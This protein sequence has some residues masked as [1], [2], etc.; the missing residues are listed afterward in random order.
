MFPFYIRQT[1]SDM[2]WGTAY[3]AS[4]TVSFWVKTNGAPTLPVRLKIAQNAAV[5]YITTVTVNQNLTWQY[6]SFTIPPPPVGTILST[7]NVDVFELSIGLYNTAFQVSTYNVWSNSN[8]GDNYPAINCYSSAGNYVEF[9]GVQ[10]EKGTIATP[11][12]F[13]PY[14]M[15]LQL[16]QRYYQSFKNSSQSGHILIGNAYPIDANN[17]V[18]QIT[19]PGGPMR[20]ATPRIVTGSQGTV[21]FSSGF[22]GA[23]TD[24]YLWCAA[25]TAF[26]TN[27]YGLAVNPMLNNII[28][29]RFADNVAKLTPN[30]FYHVF[31][32]TS[33]SFA[34][35]AEL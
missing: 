19:L 32:E 35:S 9:T 11:F 4:V 29:L 18:A 24:V 31:V 17:A 14:V 30:Q 28:M 27:F 23:Q 33:G 2:M 12:E 21:G 25:H 1:V 5:S 8:G 10:L 7:T 15:E 34:L 13:R 3:G 16:C 26:M 6:V 22:G 20:T